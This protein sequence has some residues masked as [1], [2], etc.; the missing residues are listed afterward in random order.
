MNLH[1]KLRPVL[2]L[3]L[4]LSAF[5]H[6]CYYD[7][8]ELLYGM[9]QGACNDTTGIVS[10][11]Q[12]VV[13]LLQQNCYGCHAG[14]SPSGGIQMGTY[15]ADKSIGVNGKLYGSISHSPG[16]IAMPQNAPVLNSCILAV[17]KKWIDSGTL[18][19]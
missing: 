2:V 15:A 13:P 8:A 3:A 14:V 4:F 7:N 17:I 11:S 1:L 12:K 5:I 10:Y 16:Y 6:G 9:K 18:N 19:N